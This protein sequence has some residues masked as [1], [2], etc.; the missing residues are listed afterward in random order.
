M[1]RQWALMSAAGFEGLFA[2]DYEEAATSAI[3]RPHPPD[4]TLPKPPEGYVRPQPSWLIKAL[5]QKELDDERLETLGPRSSCRRR[6][7]PYS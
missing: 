5:A 2:G 3:H 6:A 7:R 4:G 1:W